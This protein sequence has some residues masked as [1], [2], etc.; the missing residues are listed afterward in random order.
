LSLDEEA[1]G[2][3]GLAEGC[4]LDSPRPD[5]IVSIA[6]CHTTWDGDD[7]PIDPA[8]MGWDNKSA[9]IVLMS[10]QLDTACEPWE[11]ADAVGSF[12]SASYSVEYTEIEGADHGAMLFNPPWKYGTVDNPT[13]QAGEEAVD[14]TLQAIENADR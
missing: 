3:R 11:S 6:G 13:G 1:A 8:A 2:L 4:P 9:A 7:K 12:E 14:L 5:V 10:G